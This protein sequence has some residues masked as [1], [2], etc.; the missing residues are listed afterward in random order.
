MKIDKTLFVLVLGVFGITTTEFGV[1]GILP[2]LASEFQVSIDKAGWLLS[3]FAIIVAVFGPF[4]VMLSSSFDRKKVLVFSLLVFAITNIVSVWA[5]HFT[6]LLIVRM[7]PAFFHP[8]Y[9]S[10]ALAAASQNVLPSEV[11]KAIS[12]IFSG[13]NIATVLGVPLATFLVD[14]WNWQS[15]FLLSA[16]INLVSLNRNPLAVASDKEYRSK[17]KLF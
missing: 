5:N 12:T 14:L 17:S 11:P 4:M 3:A 13:L 15:S 7:L 16:M 8:V 9:W 2:E 6:F 10:I 1:I